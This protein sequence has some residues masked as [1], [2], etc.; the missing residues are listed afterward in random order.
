MTVLDVSNNPLAHAIPPGLSAL[1]GLRL[2]GLSKCALAGPVSD[3]M[4]NLVGLEDLGMDGNP[5]LEFRED[6]R[7]VIA[8]ALRKTRVQM[9]Q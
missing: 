3:S 4:T 7:E 9:G 2:L 8:G 5:S 1:G 6:A